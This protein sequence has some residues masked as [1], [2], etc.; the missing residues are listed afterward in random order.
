MGRRRQS[1]ANADSVTRLFSAPAPAP[2]IYS[3]MLILHSLPNTPVQYYSLK[4]FSNTINQY[5]PMLIL[6]PPST[7]PCCSRKAA[8]Q[9]LCICSPA[10]CTIGYAMKIKKKKM[11][12]SKHLVFAHFST[13][14]GDFF[15][16]DGKI[17]MFCHKYF[18]KSKM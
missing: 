5:S 6:R 2:Y 16:I 17:P 3:P 15:G 10:H 8:C 18:L 14:T 1:K 12:K 11:F 9:R 4:Y 7:S 13:K